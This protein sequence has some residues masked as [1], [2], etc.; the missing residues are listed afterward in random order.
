MGVLPPGS[1]YAKHS[2]RKV[3]VTFKHIPQRIKSHIRGFRT[4]GQLFNIFNEKTPTM[5]HEGPKILLGIKIS[6]CL[7]VKST[8]EK[9]ADNCD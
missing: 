1:K 5:G 9:L 4:L 2:A 3:E 6:F 8:L 7:L